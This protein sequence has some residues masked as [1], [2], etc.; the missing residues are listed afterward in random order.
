MLSESHYRVLM[1]GI[2]SFIVSKT[3]F[4]YSS[5]VFRCILLHEYENVIF[6]FILNMYVISQ[7]N[8]YRS[9]ELALEYRMNSETDTTYAAD[10]GKLQPMDGEFTF[11]KLY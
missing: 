2:S 11:G 10:W 7:S 8:M 9:A 4:T 1:I 6:I 5:H 3:Y